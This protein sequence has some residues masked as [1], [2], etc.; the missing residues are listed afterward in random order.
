MQRINFAGNQV[1][2]DRRLRRVIQTNQ[3]NWLSFIFGSATYDADRLELDRELLRQ[4]YLERGYVDIQVLSATAELAR[5]RT[6]FFLSFTVSEGQRY[7]FGQVSVSSSVPGLNAAD[8]QPLLA[9]VADRGVY[10]VKLRSTGSSSAWPSRPARRATPSSRSGRR[11]PRTPPPRTVDINFELVEGE[12]VFIE[13]IDITGNN[14]TLDRVIRRQF[15]IVEGDAFNAREIR[16]AEDRISGLG[17]FEE[18]T[19]NVR[20]GTAPGPRAGR[21][22]RSRSSRPAAS[23]SAAPS[24][25]A[26]ASARRSA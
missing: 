1:F 19:V 6:G 13:R 18:A 7:N 16:D 22:R 10:N 11:S 8:F 24:P 12:R 2:S 23:A 20:E 4:F 9:P 14:R 17:Y 25:P 26:R 15:R 3:A 5:E 21:R